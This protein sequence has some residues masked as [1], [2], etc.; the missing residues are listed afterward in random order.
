MHLDPGTRDTGARLEMTPLMDVIFLLLVFFIYAMATMTVHRGI[1][2]AL[3]QT[4][5]APL[6]GAHA[7]ITLA[8]D[9]GAWLEGEP[10]DDDAL[11][12]RVLADCAGRPILI[13]ADER[14]PIGRGLVLLSALREAGIAEVAFQT[15]PAP[16]APA[17]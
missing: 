12:A 4:A 5:D 14:V 1:D 17:P 2:V 8:A 16:E 13:S 3:P 6:P 9:G 7:V 15:R 10:T 11:V